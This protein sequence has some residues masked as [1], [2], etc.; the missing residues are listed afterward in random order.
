MLLSTMNDFRRCLQTLRASLSKHVRNVSVALVVGFSATFLSINTAWSSP[1][2][3]GHSQTIKVVDLAGRSVDVPVDVKRIILG[4]SR[5]IPAIAILDEQPL[6]R[7]AGMLAD[8]KDTD[9][10]SYRQYRSKFPEIDD[11]PKI[12]HASADSFSIETVL[13]LKPDVAI[14]GLGGHGPTARHSYLIKQLEKAGIAVIFVDFRVDPLANTPKSMKLLGEV[15]NRKDRAAEFLAFYQHEMARVN[16]GLLNKVAAEAKAPNIFI[17]SRM[18]LMDLC[19]E[20]MVRGMMASF[21][22]PVGAHNVAAPIVPGAAGV[23][24]LEYLLS[25]QPDMYI[26]TAIG[27]SNP[28]TTDTADHFSGNADNVPPYIVLGAGVKEDVA[29]ASFHHALQAPNSRGLLQL[30]AVKEGRAYAIWHHFYNTPLN[31]IAV[32]V[33]AK[34]LYPQIFADLDPR[35][36]MQSLFDRFQPVALDGTYWVSLDT[37]L[38][39]EKEVRRLGAVAND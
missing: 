25:F 21:A 15:L 28:G 38:S 9:P 22:E 10:G 34:W 14:F 5:Y 1:D 39:N 37:P 24:N 31:V 17:H 26:A 35:Q 29:R 27:S 13:T 30:K 18:G 6:S 16:R 19:C 11:I 20:T 32:Q 7:I 2:S 36:T 8:F 33:F 23:M 3:T 12:G 4:E